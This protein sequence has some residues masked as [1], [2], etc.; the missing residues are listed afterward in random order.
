[1]PE[2]VGIGD[3]DID[4]LLKADRFPRYDEKVE[5]S[6]LGMFP[7]G[8]IGNFLSAAASFGA[9]CGAIV[10]YGDDAFGKMSVEDLMKRGIDV[11]FSVCKQGETTFFTVTHLDRIGEKAMTLC[12]TPT[13]V[14]Q[15]SD[16][17]LSYVLKAKYVH[18]VGSYA[19]IV[20]PIGRA[21]KQHGVRLS[22][23]I[24][25]FAEQLTDKIKEEILENAYIVFPNEEGLKTFTGCN[26]YE[27]G[28]RRMLTQGPKI[29][30]VTR[31][32]K[33]CSVFTDTEEFSFPA[34]SVPVVDTTGAG[35]TFNGVFIACLNK[36]YELR[37]CALL[38]T[39]AAAMQ[40]QE[41]GSRN[42]LHSE[43]ETVDFLRKQGFI[44]GTE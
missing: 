17:D 32:S 26:N 15:L 11:R 10:C 33:G 7:G 42:G 8:M 40:I 23:D 36:G 13:I 16:I 14:P 35:D 31:G 5:S 9:D 41:Y 29:V 30:V 6:L 34:F 18:M 3:T 1:M 25:P 43:K 39:A 20:I 19:D 28:A 44:S 38:S 4:I 12:L 27:T 21:C 37:K 22:L 2:I 24:E